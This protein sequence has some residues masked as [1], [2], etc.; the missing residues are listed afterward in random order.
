MTSIELRFPAHRYHANPWG[1]HVNEGVAEW[2]PS[3]YRLLR[4]LYDVW[5]R[6]CPEIPEAKVHSVL[7]SLALTAPDFDLPRAAP[8]HTRA[9][10]SSNTEDV[11]DK[12][13][14][15]DG[16]VAVEPDAVCTVTWPG[17]DL[18]LEQRGTLQALLSGLN[19]LGRSE[20]WVEARVSIVGNSSGFR[21]TP[22][23]RS[24]ESG[25]AVQVACVAAEHEYL[26]KRPWLEALTFS[27]TELVKGKQRRSDP[28]LLRKVRYV[29]PKDAMGVKRGRLEDRGETRIDTIL[30]RLDGKVLPLAT[31]AIEVAEQIRTRLMG[32]HKNIAGG[33]A[34][35]S[36]LFHGRGP[37]GRPDQ[38][39]AHIY[40]LPQPNSKGRIDCVWLV[41]PKRAFTLEERR[42]VLRV[43]S[44][45]QS[46]G[47][48]PVRCVVA[49]EGLSERLRQ[50]EREV[51]SVTPFVTPRHSRKG[52]G[53][54]WMEGEVRRECSNHQM[55]EPVEIKSLAEAT[56]PFEWI[57]Y[58]RNRK[59]DP[60]R[61]G[62]GFR[63]RFAEPV[64]TPFSIGYGAHFG[65]GQ[66]A[67]EEV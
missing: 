62:Y 30:L 59:G 61:P 51:V 40:V 45:W 41:S 32:A 3:P 26:E 23:G 1:R 47:R 64:A 67:A 55:Q 7:T 18:S 6:K 12:S 33:E 44:L 60:P 11:T 10:L 29:L 4:A 38:E 36:A 39:H 16:F 48:P 22:T 49:D 13:L 66:F 43:R 19:Y 15:F 25:D 56:G 54:A 17:V 63:L 34:Y 14:I 9:Y 5:K 20:S 52:R 58:R 42:A 8:S 24:Q 21:C 28:P 2:P 57:E 65:L 35:V 37:D 53:W 46:D 31:A 50:P 27:T